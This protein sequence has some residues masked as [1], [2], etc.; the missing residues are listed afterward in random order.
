MEEMN[1][2]DGL[3]ARPSAIYYGLLSK[4]EK[5]QTRASI[6]GSEPI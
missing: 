3:A 4:N 6:L 1:R 2:M 5:N